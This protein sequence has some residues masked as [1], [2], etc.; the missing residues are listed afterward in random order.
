MTL[1]Y[2]A[3]ITYDLPHHLQ[4]QWIGQL[5]LEGD[6]KHQGWQWHRDLWAGNLPKIET[7][8]G[9]VNSHCWASTLSGYLVLHSTHTHN[10]CT[11]LFFL[12]LLHSNL[13]HINLSTSQINVLGFSSLDTSTSLICFL[14]LLVQV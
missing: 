14:K 4:E 6:R 5:M 2:H 1:W 3:N 10:H 13:L 8:L 12:L 7:W 11:S 9:Q